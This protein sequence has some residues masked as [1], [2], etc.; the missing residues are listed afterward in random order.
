MK[1]FLLLSI[2]LFAASALLQAQDQALVQTHLAAAKSA[3]ASGN[4]EDA[5]F[6]LQQA[7]IEMDKV[8]GQ[9][10]LDLLPTQ[11][12]D[13]SV[14][15]DSDQY[16]S[17]YTGFSGL[18]VERVYVSSSDPT[19]KMRFTIMND[20]PLLATLS[21]LMNNTFMASMAGMKVVRLDGYKAMIEEVADSDP[22]TINLNLPFGDSLM[23]MEWVNFKSQEE[24]TQLATEIPVEEV[25]AI[26]K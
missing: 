23:A 13:L 8:I 20:S 3:N 1:Q 7:L 15:A 12:G 5:R 16:T 6:E 24:V 4:Y 17:V 22:K 18:F 11:I 10:I 9:A 25:I 19:R 26:A 21:G 2:F 14:Q